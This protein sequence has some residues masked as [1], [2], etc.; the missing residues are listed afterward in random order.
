MTLADNPRARIGGNFPPPEEEKLP[1]PSQRI[2]SKE[3][4]RNL[5][6]AARIVSALFRVP[7]KNILEKRKGG[8]DGRAIRRFLILYARG[9]G[10]PVWECA[11]I[12]D[13]NR[14]QIGQ[15]EASY[16]D[17]LAS[18]PAIEDAADN[19]TTML[20]FALRVDTGAFLTASITEIE[21][22]NAARRAIKTARVAS[23]RLEPV[24]PPP[25]KKRPLSEA[26][27]LVE[28]NQ[29]KR[30]QS[31]LDQRIAISMAVIRK[32][33]EPGASK[34]QRADAEREAKALDALVKGAKRGG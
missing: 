15:E 3:R 18:N 27:R 25:V 10:S 5:L 17:M 11:E 8:E 14:K 29:A 13:L 2:V 30:R 19:M 9:I 1:P 26:E 28:A 20:D 24:T 33:A 31:A 21:A 16:L 34:E 23:K 4:A 7:K 12:F 6:I 22:D 32:G